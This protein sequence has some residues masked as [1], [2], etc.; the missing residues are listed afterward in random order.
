MPPP[1]S[2]RSAPS[3]SSCPSVPVRATWHIF[4]TK[5]ADTSTAEYALWRVSRRSKLSL[6]LFASSPVTFTLLLRPFSNSVETLLLA[7]AYLQM[8]KL[9]NRPSKVPLVG[10]G[11]VLAAGI[12]T[13]VTFAMFVLPLVLSVVIKLAR[14]TS[15]RINDPYARALQACSSRTDTLRICRSSLVRLALAGSPAVAGFL[16]TSLLHAAIDTAYFHSG[17]VSLYT[18]LR[19]LAAPRTL[20]LTPLN[21]LRYNLSH[22]NLAEHGLHPRWLH[23]AVNAPML[24]GAGLAVVG[25]GGA[26]LLRGNKRTGHKRSDSEEMLRALLSPAQ[27]SLRRLD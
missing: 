12:F 1:S 11:A 20:I 15:T 10:M 18:A 21:L 25:S 5:S 9:G 4:Q 27:K 7:A 2:L 8:G 16:A 23:A 26:D 13:R 6:L 24:F 17:E 22:D 14:Q 3:C 19:T